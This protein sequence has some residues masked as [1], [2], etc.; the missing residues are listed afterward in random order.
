MLLKVAYRGKKRPEGAVQGL[1]ECNETE[2]SEEGIDGP[3]RAY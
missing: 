3:Y 1:F 2:H